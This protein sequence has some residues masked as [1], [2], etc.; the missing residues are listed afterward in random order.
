M[1]SIALD[2]LK[3]NKTCE[4]HKAAW[5]RGLIGDKG[6]Q[7]LRK[8][9]WAEDEW[10][11]G[12]LVLQ[13]LKDKIQPKGRSQKNEYRSE[14]SHFRQTSKIFTEF[15]TKLKRKY[16]LIKCTINIQCEEH[17][18]CKDF[19]QRYV[20]DELMSYIYTAVKRAKGKRPN[21]PAARRT[22]YLRQVCGNW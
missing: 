18:N 7:F 15:W 22:T 12:D 4:D 16:K 21:R 13:N 10:E 14:H 19:H 17:R 8:S 5:I 20:D 6:I 1:E 9:K 3:I 2:N 11:N